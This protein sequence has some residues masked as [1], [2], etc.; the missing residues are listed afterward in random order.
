MISIL[1]GVC[2]SDKRI[3]YKNV[4]M[5]VVWHPFWGVQQHLSVQPHNLPHRVLFRNTWVLKM[6]F[7]SSLR[8]TR[9]FDYCRTVLMPL[10]RHPLEKKIWDMI[11]MIISRADG[12]IRKKNQTEKRYPLWLL[13]SFSQ[14]F[15]YDMITCQNTFQT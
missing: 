3:H 1:Q 8:Y 5:P 7:H 11:L 13:S 2:S 6:A 9:I 12:K 15:S 14:W 10:Y 4:I